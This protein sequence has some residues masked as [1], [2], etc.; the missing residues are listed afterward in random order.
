MADALSRPPFRA[1]PYTPD[2]FDGDRVAYVKGMYHAQDDVLRPWER[3]VEDNVKM[4]AGLQWQ[5]FSPL[6]GHYVDITRWMDEQERRWRQRPVI[7]RLL[8]WFMLTHARM[9]ENPAIISYQPATADRKDAMLA[10]VSDP[11]GKYLWRCG[12]MP[13]VNDQMMAWLIAAGSSYIIT[14]VDPDRGDWETWEGPAV[15]SLDRPDGTQVQRQVERAPYDQNGNVL[16]ELVSEDEYRETGEPHVERQGEITFDVPCPIQ[17]RGEWGPRPW[18]R[19]AWHSY[20]SHQRV[21]D[22]ER[23]FG[24]VTPPQQSGS[25][26]QTMEMT[27]LLFGSG[28]YGSAAAALGAEGVAVNLREGRAPVYTHF[29]A[30]TS[31]PDM[32]ETDE[33][34]GGRMIVVVGEQV[35]YDGPRPARFPNTSPIEKWEFVKLPGRHSG[36]TPVEML[37][38][39]QKSYNRGYAQLF[40]HRNLQCNPMLVADAL[41]GFK[42][43]S[44]TNKPG[45]IIVATRRANVPPLD[46]LNPPSM[47]SDVWRI[48]EALRAEMQDLGNIE[49]SE[50]RLPSLDASGKVVEELR[51]NADRFLGATLRRA[52]E[53][54]ARLMAAAFA[55]IPVIWPREKII[56]VAGEDQAQQTITVLPELF[57]YAHVNIIADLESMMPESRSERRANSMQLYGLGAFGQPGTPPA[58]T[59]LAEVLHFPHIGRALLPGGR[60]VITARQENAR[61]L[62]GAPA[63]EIPLFDWYDNAMHLWVHEDYMKGPD[64]LRLDPMTQLQFIIHREGHLALLEQQMMEQLMAQQALAGGIPD[65]SAGPGPTGATPP[66]SEGAPAGTEQAAA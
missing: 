7:N 22:I 47:P 54:Y 2:G 37:K 1:D 6:L 49:G 26:A 36:T 39:L 24:L 44:L 63:Q 53:G 15:L 19:K 43:K 31:D 35:A 21:A 9:T 30:P 14:G 32:R 20:I 17:C 18:S 33:S 60:D 8:Y 66:A 29:E 38:P 25:I 4:I 23:R 45:Q 16:A 61:L 59:K 11:I 48:Q 28:W 46:Y 50:G 34:P 64:F 52:P 3:E 51:F 57:E 41:S 62:Q 10:E 55:W 27:R 13:D 5:V 12:Q 56:S 40:E 65:A 58:I 42:A